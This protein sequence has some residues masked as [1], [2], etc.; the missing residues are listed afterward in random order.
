[1][2][3]TILKSKSFG[4]NLLKQLLE[5]SKEEKTRFKTFLVAYEGDYWQNS[6]GFLGPII[7]QSVMKT[8]RDRFVSRNS[9]NE[10]VSRVS[11]AFLKSPNWYYEK[12]GEKLNEDS[13]EN[14]NLDK[15]LTRFWNKNRLEQ[16][17]QQALNSRL[18]CGRGGLRIYIPKNKKNDDGTFK[19]TDL[20]SALESIKVEFINPRNGKLFDEDGDKFSLINYKSIIDYDTQEKVDVI[21]FSFTD[22]SQK[23]FIGLVTDREDKTF[24]VQ[25]LAELLNSEDSQVSSLDRLKKDVSTA[26]ELDNETSF[27]E[28]SGEPYV[29]EQMLQQANFINLCLT[30]AAI[31]MFETGFQQIITTNAKFEYTEV[32]DEKTGKKK[33]VPIGIESGGGVVQNFLGIEKINL[34]T[35]QKDK[36]TPGVHIKEPVDMSSFKIGKEIA[37]DA[38]LE[39]ASQLYVKITGDAAASGI[40]RV[41]AT[42]AFYLRIKK[43]KA[44][45][46][47]IGSWLL[48]SIVLLLLLIIPDEPLIK[49]IKVLFDSKID[50]GPMSPEEKNFII[51][52]VN[53]KIMSKET[54]RVMLGIDN[55][56][57]EKMLIDAQEKE[58]Q[59]KVVENQKQMNE[60]APQP[61]NNPNDK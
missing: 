42:M 45:V 39:E 59:E 12:L 28:L 14:I 20:A 25:N 37:Y 5:L 3:H 40:S 49:E 13:D 30:L 10:V 6:K 44:E 2:P 8:F 32:L 52:M 15:V 18:V 17:M 24:N 36:H 11:D 38:L 35:G 1:M 56:T 21:E 7:E 41:Q 53:N 31:A 50:I 54:A 55:P 43:Y 33:K 51:S 60:I 19:A 16:K 4:Y 58:E 22:D 46:D 48:T 61:A 23:T 27:F 34:E 47:L 29:T 57:L 9:L 26:L